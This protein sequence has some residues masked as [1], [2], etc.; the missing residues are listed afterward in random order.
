M[1]VLSYKPT[2]IAAIAEAIKKGQVV[3]CPTETA[4]G[5]LADSTN[6]Q[7]VSRVFAIKGRGVSKVSALVVASQSM[8]EKYG[9]FSKREKKIA[10][11]YWPGP[12]TIIVKARGRLVKGVVK[13]KTVGMR[14]PGNVWL[15]KLI[16][17]VG[18]PLTATSANIAGGKNS[19]SATQVKRDLDKRQLQYLVDGGRLKKNLPSTIIAIKKNM[20]HVLRQGT[21]KVKNI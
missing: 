16:Q 20:I 13:N 4:Y 18:R 11:K 12:L 15:R 2:N 3:A 19:Y 9:V 1:Q 5:L 14:V 10:K 7:A 6:A 17:K 21:I 8:A